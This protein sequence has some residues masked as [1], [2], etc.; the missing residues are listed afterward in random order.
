MRNAESNLQNE[1]DWL[2]GM[3]TWSARFRKLLP[4]YRAWRAGNLRNIWCG[5]A[6]AINGKRRKRCKT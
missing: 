1:D 3:I 6:V 5:I 2:T 4:T